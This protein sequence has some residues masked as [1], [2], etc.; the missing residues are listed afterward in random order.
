MAMVDDIGRRMKEQYEN[1]TRYA[2]RRRTYTLIR[3]DGK[4]FHEY[5][6]DCRRPFDEDLMRAMDETAIYMC[7]HIEGAQFAFTQ[8]DEISILLTDFATNQTQ[9]WF[10]GNIQKIASISASL[11]TAKFNQVRRESR[12]PDGGSG[13]E[14]P[15]ALFDAR[16]FT[17]PDP[18]EVYNYFVWRQDDASR[19][20]LQMAAQACFRPEALGGKSCDELQEML[21][22]VGVNWNSYPVGFK[23][24]RF[25]ERRIVKR[26]VEYVHKETGERHVQKDVERAVWGLVED[27]PVFTRNPAWLQRRIPKYP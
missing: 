26:D 1:R 8:S 22:Q 15:L 19:N 16:V 6:R 2:L 4:A 20:S 18:T 14:R 17:I 3:A 24:G 7:R 13:E 5:T 12:F 25:I 9:A 23:R 27:L 21:F 10:D 11:A